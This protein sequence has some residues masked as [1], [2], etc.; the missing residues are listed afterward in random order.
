[1]L[2]SY[3]YETLPYGYMTAGAAAVVFTPGYVAALSGA[4]LILAG[5][6]VWI[7][8]SDHRRGDRQ[9]F[10]L[11][12]GGLPF[13]LYEMQPFAYVIAG[14]LCWQLTQNQ[15]VYPFALIF[16]VVG[17]QIFFMRSSQRKHQVPQAQRMSHL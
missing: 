16:I 2:P 3:L 7:L 1:M 8:R 9:K 12:A 4:I 17:A 10:Y 5:A 11:K 6:L 15:F 14:L 13:W